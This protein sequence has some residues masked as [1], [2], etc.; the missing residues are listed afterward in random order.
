[1]NAIF[2]GT[3]AIPLT[4]ADILCWRALH[5]PQREA[6]TFLLDGETKQV[7][8]T[9]ADLDR[10][11]RRIA[12]LLQSRTA[13][14]ER[15]LLLYPPG[16]EYVAAVFGCFYAGVVAVP[17][18]PP[19]LNQSLARIQ[20][21]FQD[22]RASVALTTATILSS[23]RRTFARD[24][25]GKPKGYMQDLQWIETDTVTQEV[26]ASYRESRIDPFD[27]ALLQYTS[28]STSTPKGVMLTHANLIQNAALIQ[29]GMSLSSEDRGMV[30]LPPYHDMGL[31]AGILQALYTGFPTVLMAPATFLQQPL[32]WLQAISSFQV[33]ASGGPNFAYDLC[34]K[35]ATPEVIKTLDLSS[36]TLA[37]TGAEPVRAETLERFAQTFA[38]SG[39][40]PEAFYPCYGLAETTLFVSGGQRRASPEIRTFEREALESGQVVEATSDQQSSRPLVGCGRTRLGSEIAIVDPKH[41]TRCAAG[42]IGEIWVRGPNVARGY[43]GKV[44]QTMETFQAFLQDSLEGP[45]LRTGDLGFCLEEEFYVTGRL[46]DVIIIRGRNL[47][48]E[49]IEQV[50]EKSHALLRQGCC[51]VFGVESEQTRRD[52]REGSCAPPSL[53]LS[54]DKPQPLQVPMGEQLVVVQEVSRH[55]DDVGVR[56]AIEAIRQAVLSEF[57]VEVAAIELLRTG[58][59]FK[60]SSGKIQRS[61]CRRSFLAGELDAVYQWKRVEEPLPLLAWQKKRDEARTGQEP[62]GRDLQTT[63][64]LRS[65]QSL[66]VPTAPVFGHQAFTPKVQE[67][68]EWLVIHIAERAQIDARFVDIYAPFVQFGLNSLEAVGLSGDLGQWLGRSLSPTLIYDYPSINSLARYLVEG[69]LVVEHDLSR[70]RSGPT[71]STD[72]KQ[73]SV[74][75]DAIAIIGL[76]CRF[77]GADSPE[78]FWQMLHD[79]IDGISEVPASRFDAEQFYTRDQATP[80]KM[81]TRW[82]G[83][84]SDIEQF[85][86]AF[87]A[88]SPREAAQMDPPPATSPA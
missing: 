30:W 33:T 38:D 61:A 67:I 24:P 56:E 73:Q 26:I 13:V 6:Y 42:T 85:D 21:I 41:R 18:Y 54:G 5:E 60:T 31:V 78:A 68:I 25:W 50:V 28:G 17:A 7:Q 83:F 65:S 16:L 3:D 22:A 37:F 23:L 47:Y 20:T 75:T 32:R 35:K 12:A 2:G 34:I 9:Y 64:P 59:I 82:G 81:N 69:D 27:L 71:S 86:S 74:R 1:M 44:E 8:M 62:S 66:H 57:D 45:F 88:L 15:V 40:R 11:A 80:G 10:E 77:P 52:R 72:D 55:F 84:L 36:W 19:R 39:F 76:G 70:L 87:F 46:K 63:D 43:W 14:G 29:E 48:P 53:R 4:L 49:D 51:A 58:T 79:G